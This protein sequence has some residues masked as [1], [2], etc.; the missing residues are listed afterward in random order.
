MKKETTEKKSSAVKTA[1]KAKAKVE[2]GPKA[3]RIKAAPHKR[4]V[5]KEKVG[6][7]VSDKMQK[8]ITVAVAGR[9]MHPK[10]KKFLNRTSKFK[11][12]DEKEEASMG[13]KVLI[14]ETP[15]TSKTKRWRLA[16]VIEKADPAVLAPTVGQE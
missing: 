3:E 7:V 10:Y 11:A 6:I 2:A 8:T 13:D 12:H 16:Q 4:A 9:V 15:P 1:G 5:R 14:F